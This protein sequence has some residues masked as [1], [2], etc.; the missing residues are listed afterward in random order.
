MDES[1]AAEAGCWQALLA[2]RTTG[3]AVTGDWDLLPLYAPLVAAETRLAGWTVAHLGQSLDGFI[4]AADG[5]SYFVTGPQNLDHLH[6]MRALA[7]AIVVGANTVARDDPALTTRRVPGPNP[8]RVVLDSTA[9]LA[10]DRQVFTDGEARTLLFHGADCR[11]ESRGQAECIA[12][13]CIDRRLDLAA[14]LDALSARGLRCIFIEGGGAVVS[15]FLVAGLLDRL[16]VA[17][18]PVLIGEGRRGVVVPPAGR[19]LESLRPPAR[20][21]PQGADV[22]FDLA[23]GRGGDEQVLVANP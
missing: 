9:R 1:D 11:A 12:L 15:A 23:L 4:A 2:A 7:D 16:Q 14:V 17:V 21:Y 6:R 13:P 19:L 3:D 8:V 20:A 5:D 18:A 22:L 10:P